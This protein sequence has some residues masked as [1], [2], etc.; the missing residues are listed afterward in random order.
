MNQPTPKFSISEFSKQARITVRTLRF[1]EELG[2]LIP[3]EHN[4]AG[5]R[6]YGLTELAKLQQIQSLKF[7]GYPLQEIKA[8]IDNEAD[9]VIQLEK[10]LP[11]QHKL[12]TEKRNEL[13][14]GIEA[15]ERVQNLLEEGKP[16]HLAMLSSLL[17]QI[18]HEEDLKE[19]AKEYLPDATAEL[20]FSL[21]KEQQVKLD[22]EMLDWISRLTKLMQ[23]NTP[24]D[25]QEA[26]GLLIE[27]T[28]MATRH[29]LNI[30]EFAEDLEKAQEIMKQDTMD[31]QFPSMLTPEQE[32]YIM[33]IGEEMEAL[34]QDDHE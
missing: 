34:Y 26:F 17:F 1:Y 19:W 10:S 9:I 8:M 21:P 23:D 18:E 25:S 5:H 28:E 2:L 4:N 11:L 24:A 29:I 14:R 30:D 3:T 16:I 22:L 32:A 7:L 15:V 13:S 27:L 31:F 20:Y 12:L 6:L 33:K